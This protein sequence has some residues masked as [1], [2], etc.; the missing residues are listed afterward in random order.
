MRYA[1]FEN[2]GY[3]LHKL[4]GYWKGKVSAWF[5][6]GGVLQDAEQILPDGRVWAV[7][8]QTPMWK[9]IQAYGG[10]LDKVLPATACNTTEFRN[11]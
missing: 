5:G 6:P 3:V 2:G 7:Q 1:R 8:P 9:V 4:L 10:P 11:N